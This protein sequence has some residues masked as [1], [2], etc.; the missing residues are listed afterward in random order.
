[1]GGGELSTLVQG[2]L[3]GALSMAKRTG[4]IDREGLAEILREALAE[5]QPAPELRNCI[6][7]EQ[8]TAIDERDVL[9]LLST[10]KTITELGGRQ[11]T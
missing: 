7:A 2:R 9:P 4:N 8:R 11:G 3:E 6:C 10:L 5:I 1:M